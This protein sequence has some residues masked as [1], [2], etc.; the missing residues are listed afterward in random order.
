MADVPMMV[1]AMVLEVDAPAFIPEF[2]G[3][4]RYLKALR[5]R[6]SYRAISLLMKVG[7][8]Q[9]AHQFAQ[10]IAASN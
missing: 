6:S 3:V 7:R 10:M 8:G 2:P 9:L 4:D 5:E 1:L